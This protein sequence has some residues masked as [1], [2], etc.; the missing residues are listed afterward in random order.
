MRQW[1]LGG[2]KKLKMMKKHWVRITPE[3]VEVDGK[4]LTKPD[5]TVGGDGFVKSDDVTAKATGSI[6]D[7]GSVINTIVVSGGF[8][9]RI[10]SFPSYPTIFSCSGT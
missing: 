10:I 1:G 3:G 7:V 6:T 9:I 5:V 2:V 8:A 4:A